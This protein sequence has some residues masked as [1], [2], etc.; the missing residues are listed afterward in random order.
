[1]QEEKLSDI[2]GAT[3]KPKRKSKLP[4]ESVLTPELEQS[5][6][7]Y[8]MRILHEWAMEN[9]NLTHAEVSSIIQCG[10]SELDDIVDKVTTHFSLGRIK[11][12]HINL[13]DAKA[14]GK[15]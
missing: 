3:D 9:S 8:H 11:Q 12:L 4:G 15:A 13:N 5:W 2:W 1:M 6:I 14:A 7:I 10:E